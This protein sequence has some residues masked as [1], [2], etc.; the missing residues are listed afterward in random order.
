MEREVVSCCVFLVIIKGAG[1]DCVFIHCFIWLCFASLPAT[2]HHFESIHFVL[3]FLVLLLRSISF[4]CIRLVIQICWNFNSN[5]SLFA[6]WLVQYYSFFVSEGIQI[7]T[8]WVALIL[9]TFKYPWSC[10]TVHRFHGSGDDSEPYCCYLKFVQEK[11][12]DLVR[13]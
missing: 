5:I 10:T 12:S 7:T 4:L 8:T 1:T 6:L 13:L 11:H 3:A 2:I 9:W